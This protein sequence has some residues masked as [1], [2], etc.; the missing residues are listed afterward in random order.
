MLHLRA[1]TEYSFRKAYGPINNLVGLAGEAMGIADA[2][3]WGHVAFNNACKKANVKPIFGVEIGVVEDAKERSKQPINYMAFI[4]KNN[5]GLAEIY[6]LVTKST[7]KENFYYI[8]RISYYDLFEVS[9]NVIILTGTNP[10]V[11]LIPLTKKKHIYFEINPM[12]SKKSFLWAKDK[13]F[14]FVA[15]SDNYYPKVTD[16]KAYEVLV[17]MNRTERTKPMHLLNE[18]ELVD[19]VP[20]IPDEA[21]QMTYKIADEC[22]VDLP[23][24]KMISFQ[25]SKTLEEMCID[26]AESRGIDLK[27]KVYKDRLRREIDMIASKNF[28]DY[29]YVIADMINYA[30][31]HMLV[32][33]ARGSSAGS[34]VCYLIGITDIDP[35][36]FDLL[37]ER[38]IDIT[39]ADLP[40]IDIDFQ[41]DRREMVFEYLRQKY[42]AEKVA[43]LG[44][45]SRYKAK[46]TIT[47][48][49]KELGIPAWEVN[50]LK[51]AIIERSGGDARAAMC[52]MDTFND[53]DIG[54]EVLKK[55]PQIKIAERMENHARHSGVH[56]AGII[57]TEKPVSEYCSVSAQT[58]AAQIDKY[59]AESLNLLKIDALGLRTLSVLNDVLEQVNWTKEKIINFPLEDQKAFDVL[60]KER[61][62]GIFQFE[63]YALQ[64]LTRQMKISN[65]EDIASITALARP[66]P[67]TSGGTTKYIRRKIG[68]EPI[69]YLHPM[70]ENITKVTFGVVVYQEQVMTIARDIGK[71]S[72]E[73]V[74]QLRKAMSKSLGEEFFDRYWKKFKV[75]AEEQGIPEDESIK[76]WKNINTMGSWAFNRSHAIA[77]GLV[78]YWC[79]VLKSR[80]PLEFAAACLRNVKDE[81]QGVKLLRE[82][83]KEGLGYKP[84]DK[85]KS[86][87]NWSVQDGELIGGLIGIKGVGPKMAE[88]IIE[89]RKFAQPL[90][91]RQEKL[92]DQGETPFDDI[93]ECER[94][95]GHI[96]KDPSAHN[97][98]T[99]ITDIHN[100]EADNPGE[101]VV[102]GKLVEKNLRDLNEAVN[103]AKRG[104]RRAETNNLWL[105]MK[106]EDDTGPILAG[107]DRWKYPK[108]GKPIVED[109]KIGD[110]YLLKGQIRKGFRKLNIDKWRKL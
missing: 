81:D 32:G 3:T 47:E 88:D 42:G 31:Q 92:L 46:S 20:W 11:G 96:K 95:F 22:N 97:I 101:F 15:T 48:V 56:A 38:F 6:Q 82:V 10:N 43:H 27:N 59:D 74:S 58:G 4:A 12:T 57:I 14:Q 75:G 34:L 19:C 102:F 25:P 99:P 109:G 84:Y 78:S 64:S 98:K 66:G 62:A 89:R 26:A 72:W 55:Y 37:F 23:I 108:L 53:L 60:N 105:N 67:L 70:A 13:R 39:R 16:K 63:G 100:L 90:T 49:A 77:Y 8:P 80:F 35:I 71:L 76:I 94:R 1:R 106:F 33:P 17:G 91:P 79:C 61:H 83:V 73:D 28:E 9:E 52:I 50:D 104:G 69:T 40:D 85:Y 30:K 2:G 68:E 21:M 51:G 44:T 110:W 107:I 87:L 7:S 93:F 45:V 65:F 29:F 103:L 24:A 5:S 36:K 41:D 86:E 54:K 18:Y